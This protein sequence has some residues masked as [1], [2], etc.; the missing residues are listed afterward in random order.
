MSFFDNQTVWF[1]NETLSP[2]S[3]LKVAWST[4]LL[5]FKQTD[6]RDDIFFD[7]ETIWTWTAVYEQA[8]WWV[9]MSVSANNDV[10]I[11]QSKIHANYVSWNP[12]QIEMTSINLLPVTWTIKRVGYYTSN[13]TTPFNS[14]LDWCF[15][16]TDNTTIYAKVMKE[17]TTLCNVPQAS[18]NLD[19][20]N[21]TWASWI[22]LDL[23]K[24]QILLMDFLYLWGTSV[25]F[26]TIINWNIIW[27]HRYD[28]SNIA[29]TTIFLSPNKP[30]RWEIR[31]TWWASH[32][33]HICWSVES[34]WTVNELWVVREFSNWTTPIVA[35]TVW[36][37]YALLWIELT[38]RNWIVRVENFSWFAWTS[39]KFL[40][41]IRLN[42]IVAGAFTYNQET[43]YP[44]AVATWTA[45]N[46]VTWWTILHQVYWESWQWSAINIAVNQLR[47][48][49]KI[50]WTTDK[51]VLCVTPLINST[52]MYW[53]M[54][55]NSLI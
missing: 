28:H 4:K 17:W 5:S 39:D 16:E 23:S 47:L 27:F 8:N 44:Y 2:D 35:A 21:W 50:N 42:P 25:R 9:K 20:L 29:N 13:T 14:N 52:D 38:Y 36:V 49:T 55:I 32:L 7:T 22:T 48:W 19:K 46:T 51:I 24:F 30:M 11:R 37:Y 41:Q 45:A 53:A 12:Q 10:V 3:K 15:L 33:Y 1:R 6:F 54:E 26:W 18:W 40:I 34:Q 31:S 43:W